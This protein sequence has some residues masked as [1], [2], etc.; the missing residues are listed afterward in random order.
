MHY[1]LIAVN[2][3]ATVE[4]AACPEASRWVLESAAAAALHWESPLV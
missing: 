4:V 3:S 2:R 1:L